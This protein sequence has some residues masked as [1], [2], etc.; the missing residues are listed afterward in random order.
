MTQKAVPLHNQPATEMVTSFGKASTGY[1]AII[2][3]QTTVTTVH[4][5]Q[6]D[7]GIITSYS[8]SGHQSVT[9][10]P[11]KSASA[12]LKYLLRDGLEIDMSVGMCSNP[13]CFS[14]QY[15]ITSSIYGNRSYNLMLQQGP[16]HGAIASR[17]RELA[18]G[19][20]HCNARSA[21][22][23]VPHSVSSSP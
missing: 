17:H 1:C 23:S 6:C 22:R 11:V 13:Q 5:H 10:S 8:I 7:R 3:R 18:S 4:L 19:V 21:H 12:V 16:V 2:A 14:L 15:L 20:P 9:A